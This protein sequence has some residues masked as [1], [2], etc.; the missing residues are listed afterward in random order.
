MPTTCQRT[1]LLVC[2]RSNSSKTSFDNLSTCDGINRE[3]HQ[4]RHIINARGHQNEMHQHK[5]CDE[6]LV[7][8]LILGHLTP[9][10]SQTI[11]NSSREEVR[12]VRLL[13]LRRWGGVA[14]LT[15]RPPLS[16]HFFVSTVMA[17]ER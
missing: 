16:R 6:I 17:G 12:R 5:P 3:H 9:D 1:R 13:V 4:T 15:E 2:M 10:L 11:E 7:A 8:A 14:E